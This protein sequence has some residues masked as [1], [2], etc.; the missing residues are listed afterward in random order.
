[1]NS[2]SLSETQVARVSEDCIG[3]VTRLPSS[4]EKREIQLYL[5]HLKDL[6]YKQVNGSELPIVWGENWGT[7][8]KLDIVK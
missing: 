1:M 8:I 3:K 6:G 2:I 4:E 7:K 5:G